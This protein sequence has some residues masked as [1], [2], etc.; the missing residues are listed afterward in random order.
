MGSWKGKCPLCRAETKLAGPGT[1]RGVIESREQFR[2]EQAATAAAS[3]GETISERNKRFSSLS[4]KSKKGKDNDSKGGRK[5]NK[6][7]KQKLRNN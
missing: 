3:A 6:S 4:K 1:P 5:K 7:K 2:R